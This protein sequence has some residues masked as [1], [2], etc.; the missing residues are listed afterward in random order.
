MSVTTSFNNIKV[1]EPNSN[2]DHG[3]SNC[4]MLIDQHITI[5]NITPICQ[6]YNFILNTSIKRLL[7]T[8]NQYMLGTINA[9]VIAT[10]KPWYTI[11]SRNQGR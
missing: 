8:T 7:A 2:Y 10:K 6:K 5:E 1:F 3:E 4:I 11:Y 9:I